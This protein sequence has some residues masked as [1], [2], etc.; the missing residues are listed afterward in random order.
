MET[1]PAQRVFG[2]TELLERI[3]L[4]ANARLSKVDVSKFPTTHRFDRFPA[5]W[6]GAEPRAM[7]DYENS[8]GREYDLTVLR[9]QAGGMRWL[10]CKACRVSRQFHD[11][12]FQSPSVQQALFLHWRKTRD[13]NSTPMFNPL[14]AY[15]F[16]WGYFHPVD[17]DPNR[18]PQTF[19]AL[20]KKFV[21]ALLYEKAI[22][23]DMFPVVPPI[24]HVDVERRSPGRY[25]PGVYRIEDYMRTGKINFD[26]LDEDDGL[27]MGLLFDLCEEW[28]EED[29]NIGFFVEWMCSGDVD[30]SLRLERTHMRAHAISPHSLGFAGLFFA[31]RL[32]HSRGESTELYHATSVDRIVILL[33][34]YAH[35]FRMPLLRTTYTKIESEAKAWSMNSID[36]DGPD[37]GLERY[38]TAL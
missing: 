4:F 7:V 36:W 30:P 35:S 29:K 20:R 21:K 22:W 28:N 1:S 19:P 12:I 17:S 23:R 18:P 11:V 3:L 26:Q 5:T 38:V 14:L 31:L 9:R 27:R 34:H 25:S 6:T 16:H 37:L 24:R 10:L 32:R 15:K 33:C 13:Q 2:I 8:H